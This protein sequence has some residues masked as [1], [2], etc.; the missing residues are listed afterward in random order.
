[1]CRSI[2]A[3]QVGL[4]E[5]TNLLYLDDCVEGREEAKN[6]QRLDDKWEVISGDVI[7]RAIEGT[8]IVIAVH[9]ILCMTLSGGYKRKCVSRVSE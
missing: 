7:G 8:P 1:M 4:S 9:G 5:A 6:R 2:D 3:R